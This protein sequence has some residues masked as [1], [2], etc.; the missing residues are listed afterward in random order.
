MNIDLSNTQ[1]TDSFIIEVDNVNSPVLT[2]QEL[3]QILHNYHRCYTHSQSQKYL[4]AS[5][6]DK[7]YF[8]VRNFNLSFLILISQY[9]A[10]RASKSHI[11][12]FSCMMPMV[13]R[14]TSLK[15]A[16]VIS[17]STEWSVL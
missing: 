2:S 8:L 10:V 5:W 4:K 1:I 15:A 9:S 11:S 3:Y 6:A 14:F 16:Q 12:G 7:L 13:F 17:H